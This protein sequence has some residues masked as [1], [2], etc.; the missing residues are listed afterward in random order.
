MLKIS[1]L[2]FTLLSFNACSINND[3]G[4]GSATPSK[5]VQSDYIFYGDINNNDVLKI[6][7]KTMELNNTIHSNGVYP[8]EIANGFDNELLVLNRGDTNIGLLNNSE[9]TGTYTLEFQPRSISLNRTS[10]TILLC[11]SSDPYSQIIAD[12]LIYSDS[13][14]KE[15]NSFGGKGATGHP[16]WINEKYFFLLDRTENSIE[17]Y[18]VGTAAPVA[19]LQTSSSVH[20][21][22]KQGDY[23]YGTLEGVREG[24]SPGI[25]KFKIAY[26][27]FENVNESLLSDFNNLPVDFN[28]TTWGFHHFSFHP[29]GKYLYTGSYEGNV[30]V[31][32]TVNLKLVDSFKAGLGV[33]H[34]KFY[35]NT[36]ITTNHFDTFKSVYDAIDPLHNKFIK[37][38]SLSKTRVTGKIMQSHT[39]FIVGDNLYFTYNVA[40]ESRLYKMSLVDYKVEYLSL[41]T[42]YCVMGVLE[43]TIGEAPDLGM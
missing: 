40:D 37:N 17:L 30:F 39:S 16:L 31:F 21:L 25:V 36:L 1:L 18:E 10:K 43:K 26:A 34:F 2:L 4:S 11:S 12:T 28:S 19:K 6:N 5:E 15:P 7:Y 14:Y 9:V 35:Q 32:D 33:G 41:P 24:V 29:D 8:Y 27:K 3:N 42:S 22:Q 13:E 38:V 20:Q 23:F